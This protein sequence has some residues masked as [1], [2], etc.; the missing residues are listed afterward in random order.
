MG[1]NPVIP[2]RVLGE[3][4]EPRVSVPIEN[5]TNPAEVADPEPAEEP[6]APCLG[7]QGFRVIPPNQTS[8]LANEPETNLATSTAPDLSSSLAI[9]AVLLI[10]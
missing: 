1:L 4:I 7:S 2:L 9:V 10:L 6:L 3:T 5:P 8:P